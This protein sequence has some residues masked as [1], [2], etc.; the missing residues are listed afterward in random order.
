MT[1]EHDDH[2]DDAP[3]WNA[4]DARLQS[5]YGDAEPLHFAAALPLIAGGEDPLQGIS[6]YKSR[7]GG[8]A[9]WHFVTYGYSE[10]YEKENEDPESSG[11]GFEMTVRVVDPEAR[12]EPPGW[13]LSLLQNL[14]RYV[15]HSG[16]VFEVGHY[17]TLNGPIALGRDTALVAAAFVEDPELGA[18]DTPNGAVRF[19]QLVGVTEDEYDAIRDWDASQLVQ[20]LAERDPALLTD[21][22]RRSVLGTPAIAARV[23]EGIA[24]DGSSMSA[25]FASRGSLRKGTWEVAANSV[26]DL[27]RLVRGRLAFGRDA[28]LYWPDGGVELRAGDTTKLGKGNKLTLDAADRAALLELPVKRGDYPLPSGQL[29]VRVLPIPILDGNRKKVTREIG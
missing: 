15:F 23:R 22:P 21:L 5:I 8:R 3:G 12:D 17:T 16:N 9:H 19:V 26:D 11:F 10:L 28:A 14:A 13:V 20:L 18:M 4:I 25:V 27:K 29:T 1:A 24:R 7:F 2:D 6:A